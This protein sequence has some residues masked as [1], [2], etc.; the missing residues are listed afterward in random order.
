VRPLR[1]IGWVAGLVAVVAL[2]YL[3]PW[4]EPWRELGPLV[5][6]LGLALIGLLR[7]LADLV[8]SALV[9]GGSRPPGDNRPAD[10]MVGITP[11]SGVQGEP[12]PVDPRFQ[13]F[14]T[15]EPG[16]TQT[17]AIGDAAGTGAPP[18][19]LGRIVLI[20]V[21]L[22]RDGRSWSDT[23]IAQAHA[24]LLRAGAWL[25][26]EAI[27]WSAPVNLDLAG[28][29]FVA[30]DH[31]SQD[32][33]IA[34]SPLGE[35]M[36]PFETH[37]V[38]KA[39][40]SASR[41]AASL[42]FADAVALIADVNPRVAAD[43]RV[44]LLHP[45]QAGHSLAVPR[46]ETELAGVSLAVCYAREA[47][48]PEPLDRPPFTDPVTIV[49]ELLHLFGARD[50]YGVSLRSFPPRSVTSREIM[51]LDESSLARSRIDPLTTREIGW[52]SPEG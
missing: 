8:R 20:S 39:L 41:A 43:A 17:R 16:G 3:L 21:F 9:P 27:R 47:N 33:E 7:A 26:R 50:K 23:E 28:T 42:G 35:I 34:F 6:V 45:R 32:V 11:M 36:Q 31:A 51:R 25:E 5:L 1:N 44:W 52:T 46:D 38:T 14:V 40:T 29:Y 19:L 22:G 13:R 30:D 10:G 49:H 18:P 48:F 12:N 4:S 15:R 24:A 2:A 37:A